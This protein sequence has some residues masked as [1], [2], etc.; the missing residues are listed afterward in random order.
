MKYETCARFEQRLPT[1]KRGAN[2]DDDNIL[3]ICNQ[4]TQTCI[5]FKSII[6]LYRDIKVMRRMVQMKTKI[7]GST[8][9]K[10]L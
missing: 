6:I 10:E 5:N 7:D 9:N 4:L 2:D 1:S 3:I 8:T